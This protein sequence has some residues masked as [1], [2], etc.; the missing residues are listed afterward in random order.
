MSIESTIIIRPLVPAQQTPSDKGGGLFSGDMP[1]FEDVLDAINPLQHLPV[2]S[3]I[4]R[5]E[6]SDGMSIFSRLIGGM[7]FGGPI[8]LLS[9]A[10]N[11]GVEAATGSDIGEHMI[12][13]FDDN[14]P[15]TTQMAYFAAK[16][17][18]T[19]QLT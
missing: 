8:G 16:Y 3:S 19:Q 6:T 17:A 2:V 5:S 14:A 7:L 9:A 15:P 10:V 4:Y 13:I 18:N 11:A 1:S 12:A